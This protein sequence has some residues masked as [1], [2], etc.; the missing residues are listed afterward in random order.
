MSNSSATLSSRDLPPPL[1]SLR[2]DD[3]L[4]A[5]LLPKEPCGNKHRAKIDPFHDQTRS[6]TLCKK[7]AGEEEEEEEEEEKEADEDELLKNGGGLDQNVKQAF[8]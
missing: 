2:K 6:C 5:L 1:S 7:R 4:M 8:A 3:E